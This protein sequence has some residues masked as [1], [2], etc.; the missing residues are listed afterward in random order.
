MANS[1]DLVI[2]CGAGFAGDRF[3]A[4]LPVIA[5]LSTYDCPR[6]LI[7]EVLAE[8]TLAIAQKLKLTDPGKGYSPW[9]EKY[10]AAA[11]PLC[12]ENNIRIVANFGSANA[13]AAAHRIH[14]LGI[15]SGDRIARLPKVAYVEGDDLLTY[16]DVA[17]VGQLPCIEGT[18]IG[19]SPVVAANA[20][21]G[22]SSLLNALNTDADVIVVGRTTDSAL[23]LAPLIQSLNILPN[24]YDLLA[25][26][27]LAG[28]LIECGSQITG[29]YFA[30]PPLKAVDNLANTGF[31]VLE[32]SADG[33]LV[34]TKP[35]KTGGIVNRAT[36]IE[37]LLYEIH[38]PSAYLTPDVILD[39][40]GVTV[41]EE[42]ENRVSVSGARGRK[43]TDTLKATVSLDAGWL[44]EAEITYA[45]NNALARAELAASIVGERLSQRGVEEQIRID[46]IGASSV[47]D[48]NSSAQ[49]RSQIPAA[50]GEY[51]LRAAIRSTHRHVAEMLTDEVL[52]LY[53]CGP[54]GGG[55]VRHSVTP[56]LTTASVLLERNSVETRVKS[57]LLSESGELRELA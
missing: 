51:R 21:L 34:V 5:A 15:E 50:D 14:Q 3:D 35:E 53:C 49:R 37:Q 13:S 57:Y 28:H 47:F 24:D 56:S 45:G 6:F 33:S 19:D 31:P 40:S 22:A 38:D 42:S 36:V 12:L 18:V 32:F 48:N 44:G 41:S 39:L 23:V 10:L 27:I 26:G 43:P 29:G 55:G 16:M 17:E 20:Y 30:D 46:L 2:G 1:P 8:R 52:S 25:A 9:L 7:Y 54:A 11:L 4:A